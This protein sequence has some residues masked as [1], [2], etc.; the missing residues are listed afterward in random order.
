MAGG[1]I[2]KGHEE[3]CIRRA[4]AVKQRGISLLHEVD[5]QYSA[6]KVK[7]EDLLKK[8]QQEQDSLSHKAVQTSRQ[9]ARDLTGLV[10]QSET[11]ASGWEPTP[12]TPEPTSC[13]TTPEYKALFKEIFSCIKKT[14]QEID[15]QR[16]KYPSLSSYS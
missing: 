13:P 15:E 16:T 11:G 6:L 14:K 4:K 5:T 12:V 10:T 3:T 8:C 2:V 9:L 7:Y 1:D